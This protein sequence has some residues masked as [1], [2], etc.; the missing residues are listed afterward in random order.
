MKITPITLQYNAHAANDSEFRKNYKSTYRASDAL[1]NDASFAETLTTYKSLPNILLRSAFFPITGKRMREHYNEL[2][3]S[4]PKGANIT[5]SGYRL[6]QR[7]L[8]VW[9]EILNLADMKYFSKP[10]RISKYQI[11][12][13]LELTGSG[14]NERTLDARLKRLTSATL[15]IILDGKPYYEGRLIDEVLPE[16]NRKGMTVRLNS[17][18]AMMLKDNEYTKIDWTIWR[19]LKGKQLAQWLHCFYSTHAKPF[20]LRTSTLRN[21]CGSKSESESSFLQNLK[22]SLHLLH[23]AYKIRKKEFTF[24]IKGNL[25]DITK[26]PSSSQHRHTQK[27]RI[28]E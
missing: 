24:V 23:T 21:L 27:N 14:A 8:G 18:L 15:K 13:L 10:F 19:A 12:N 16:K 20:P 28:S 26:T 4:T 5:Y 22:S 3:I 2:S 11:L 25:V 1:E 7:D 9:V 6:D 17:N